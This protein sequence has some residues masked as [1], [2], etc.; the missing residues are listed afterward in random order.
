VGGTFVYSPL[1]GTTPA[2]GSDTLSVTFTPTDST[3]YVNATATVTLTVNK[4]TPVITWATPSAITFGTTLSATQLN[5]TAS[6]AGTFVYSPLAGSTP[7]TGSDTLSVTFTPTDATDYTTATATVTLTVTKA[8]PVITWA[9]PAAITFGTVLSGTQLN[10]TAS[11]GGTFVYSPLAGTTPIAGSDTLSVTFTPTD[12]TDFVNATA[13]V[14][15]TVNKATPVITWATPAAIIFGTT[16]SGTQ[17]NATAS[18]GGVFVYSPLAGTTPATGSDTLSVTFTPT[19]TTDY[20]TATATVTLTV[21]KATPVITW[22]TPAAITFGTVLSATQLNA[23]A[24]VA[25]TFVY[26]PLSG[27]RPA[28][29]SDTLSVTFTPTDAT[30]YTTATATV[31]L[32]V[33]KATPVITWATPSAITFGTTLSATQLNAT[34]STFGTFVYSPLAGT[35]P[36]TGSDTLSVT[37]TPTDAANFTTAT[38]TVI[39]TVTKATPVIT[40]ATPAPITFGTV[41]SGTQL[42]ATASVG[43]T[44]VYSPLAG[45]TPATGSDT[46]SVTFTP[47]D[48]TDYANASATVTLTVNKATPVITWATPAAITF[49]TVLSGTQLN[50]TASTAGTFVYNPLAG[51][52]PAGGSDTLSVTFTPT[53]A[54]DYTT[55]TA[56]VTL[57]VNKATPTITWATPAA[58]T[59]GTKLGATQLDATASVAGT[60]VYSP[61]SGTTPATGSDTLSVTFT[62]TAAGNYATATATVT[63]TVTKATPTVTWATPA[64]ITFGTVLS[65]T[66]LNATASVAGTFVYS[67]LAGTTPATGSD[68]LSVTFTPTDAADYT[69]ATGTVTLTVNKATPTIT[70]ATPAPIASGTA[71]SITQL[72][73]TASVAGTFVYTPAAGVMPAV[74]LDTLSVTFTPTDTVDYMTATSTVVVTVGDFFTL[75]VTGVATDKVADGSTAVFNFTVAPGAPL[76]TLPGAVMFSMTGL[77]P[78][79]TASFSPATIAS[80][81][82]ATTV[83]LKIHTAKVEAGNA[84]AKASAVFAMLLLP[85]MGLVS[86]RRGKRKVPHMLA[87]VLLAVLTLGAMVGLTS[88]AGSTTPPV[89]TDYTV[90]LT[91]TSGTLQHSTNLVVAVKQ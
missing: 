18:V 90:V 25:G 36:A 39:L 28:A 45:T 63:L 9:T 64:A 55:A 34:A 71:L 31:T 85:L 29:G 72:D 84:G 58:I 68:T 52:T 42:N 83:R 88:C 14:T 76:T 40:W 70:W 59:F 89:T 86:L 7:A 1:A 87:G 38:A 81:S 47:T 33:N 17:L 77:P 73:A 26:T 22:A 50:A 61:L 41:L 13:T 43:G 54:A 78:G 8:T 30:D 46:L 6:V 74:G 80:G 4:A 65:A 20:N 79:A 49:G 12:T 2:T 15:L 10:A 37:F 91:A 62:P 24:S 19:D 53:D 48:T 35:T 32:T 67:P 27:S 3:D 51:T 23:T 69:T 11:V 75:A 82:P 5:A 57:T 60:F 56:T 66:Q 16:L 21:S 44:F